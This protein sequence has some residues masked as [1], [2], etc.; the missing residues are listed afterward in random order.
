MQNANYIFGIRTVIEA[1]NADKNISKLLIKT[2]SKSELISEL[3]LLVAQK[4]IPY[5]YVPEAKINSLTRKNH[6]GVLAFISPIE[7]YSIED[8]VPSLFENG[9]NP[10]ILV[11]DQLTDIRNFGAIVRTAECAGVN[12]IVIPQKGAASINADAVKTS[13]GALHVIPVCREKNLIKTVKFLKDSGI[14][15]IA[16]TEKSE[17][18][19][20]QSDYTGP[21]ALVLGAEDSGIDPEILRISHEFAKI[22]VFGKIASLNVSVAAGILMYECIRQRAI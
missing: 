18:L 1:I 14:Q 9:I 19:Y 13:A 11:L 12:A 5:Q 10:F 16:V 2:N 17:K 4:N 21:V 7:F 6:Q 3:L 15:V 8:I 22:P 20:T